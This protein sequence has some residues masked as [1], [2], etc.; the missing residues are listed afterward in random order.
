[1]ARGVEGWSV[2]RSG[3]RLL[4]RRVRLFQNF[5]VSPLTPL[6]ASALLLLMHKAIGVVG[7]TVVAIVVS[8]IVVRASNTATAGGAF[9]KLVGKG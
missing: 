4:T 1:M 6:F 5:H 2:A 9:S 7:V 3:A 8:I